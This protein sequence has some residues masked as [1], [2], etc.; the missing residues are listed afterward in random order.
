MPNTKVTTQYKAKYKHYK[1]ANA[2]HKTQSRTQKHEKY[3]AKH[4]TKKV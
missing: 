1:K 4:K 3:D 2:K